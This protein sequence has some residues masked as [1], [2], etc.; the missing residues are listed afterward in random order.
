MYSLDAVAYE[1][2][3][4][5]DRPHAHKLSEVQQIVRQSEWITEGIH[6]GWTEDLLEA[7]D[8][9]FWLSDLPWHHA[10][11]RILTR[12]IRGA[13]HEIGNQNGWRKF[14]RFRDYARHLHQLLSVFITSRIYYKNAD[15][16]HQ[17]TPV[18]PTLTDASTAQMLL[19]YR[20]KLVR[21]KATSTVD[22]LIEDVLVERAIRAE[23]GLISRD[24]VIS[25]A[26]NNYNYGLYLRQAIDSALAQYYHNIE[27]IVVDDGSTDDSRAIIQEYGDKI[28]SVL[29]PNGGQASAFNVGFAHSRGDIVIFLDADD[30]LLPTTTTLVLS[31]FREWPRTAKVQY[32]MAIIDQ[33]G[34]FTGTV[35][36]P[37]HLS[38]KS[39][40]M[41]RDSLLFPDDMTFMA[42]SGNAFSSWVLHKIMPMPEHEFHI[43]ADLY[44]SHLSALYGRVTSIDEIGAYYRIHGSNNFDTSVLDLNRIRSA[45]MHMSLMHQYI[46]EHARALG[47][48]EIVKRPTE[49]SSISF[50]G[51]RMVSLRLDPSRHP[52]QGDTVAKL[53]RQ[54]I[55]ASFLRFDVLWPLRILFICWF[56]AM[57][58]SP[59]RQAVWLAERFLYA[60][61]RGRV[62]GALALLHGTNPGR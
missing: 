61:T 62:N 60:E 33:Y 45:I 9:I 17:H 49:V 52:V 43:L 2:P 26:I 15:S 20:D 39:G 42:T 47:L 48:L 31:A 37:S 16:T 58:G 27:V 12:F 50:I 5:A 1:G 35:K 46:E 29:K 28:I 25:I 53:L 59:R 30:V 51:H 13:M 18:Q 22:V 4:F 6:I 19:Q 36:P 11:T 10:I 56:L 44:V 38:L 23:N 32:R 41:I 8:L 40:N 21:L 57:A 55:A 34:R 3:D 24:P 7:A 14:A 54:G